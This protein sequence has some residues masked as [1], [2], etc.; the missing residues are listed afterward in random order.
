MSDDPTA[1]NPGVRCPKCGCRH[2]KALDTR[3]SG[4]WTIRRRQCRHCAHTLRTREQAIDTPK[5]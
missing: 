3:R 1:Q 2:L 5:P 4:Q